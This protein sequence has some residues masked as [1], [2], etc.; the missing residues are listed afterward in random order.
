MLPPIWVAACDSQSRRNGRFARTARAPLP[1]SSGSPFVGT[2]TTVTLPGSRAAVI[3]GSPRSTN[4]GEAPL[5]HA[6]GR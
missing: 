5:E 2:M 1:G 4:A 6:A 3:A